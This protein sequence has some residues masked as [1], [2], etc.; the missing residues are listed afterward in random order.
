MIHPGAGESTE[1]PFSGGLVQE[2][3]VMEREFSHDARGRSEI[4]MRD[5]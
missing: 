5:A 3:T 1:S 4:V 2:T